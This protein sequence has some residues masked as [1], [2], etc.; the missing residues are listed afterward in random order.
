MK[1]NT[2]VDGVG[3][4]CGSQVMEGYVPKHDAAVVSRSLDAGADVVGKTNI[5]DFAFTGTGKS[6]A[7]GATLNPND[8]NHLP[9]GSSSGSA[10][11]VAEGEVDMALGGDQGGSV[12]APAS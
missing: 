12:R 6:S 10:V 8:P 4:T 11:V 7:F 2:A 5:D 9:G 1:D 3:M